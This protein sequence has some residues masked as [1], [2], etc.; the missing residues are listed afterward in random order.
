MA[1]PKNTLLATGRARIQSNNPIAFQYEH[2]LMVAVIEKE[3]GKILEIESNTI[4]GLTSDF[5]SRI[6]VGKSLYTD[7]DT[8]CAEIEE[9]YYGASRKALCSCVKDMYSKATSRIKDG[10]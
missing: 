1:Y 8:I 9:R 10:F 3:S 4:C 2:L 5:I 7:Q 6:F